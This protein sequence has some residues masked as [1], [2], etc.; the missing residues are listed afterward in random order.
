[1]PE[2]AVIV[3]A[4]WDPADAL[5]RVNGSETLLRQLIQ[6]FLEEAPKQLENLQHGIDHS[7]AK[8]LE[9]AAHRL[10]GEL[11]Y[12]GLP[13]AAQK[14]RDFERMG[15]EGNLQG[16]TELFCLFRAELSAASK[17]MQH[18]LATKA[19]TAPGA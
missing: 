12:F 18:L 17:A 10:R 1:M 8:A 4:L 7:D 2:P 15:R 6:I 14:A 13:N 5:R 9:M 11:N 19:L 16:A 3:R